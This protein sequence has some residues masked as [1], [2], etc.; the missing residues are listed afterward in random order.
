MTTLVHRILWRAGAGLSL[1]AA[2]PAMASPIVDSFIVK[3]SKGQIAYRKDVTAAEEDP[4]VIFFIDAPGLANI[5]QLNNATTLLDASGD[6]ADI[7][8][9]ALAGSQIDFFLA[10]SSGTQGHPTPFGGSGSISLPKGNGGVFDATM[11]LDDGLQQQG[12]TASYVTAV[13]AV[14]DPGMAAPL[15]GTAMMGLAWLRRKQ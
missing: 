4:T 1:A 6:A 7:F 9:V 14:P 13:D 3:D 5:N 8:G 11:Y 15:L 10:F 12:W 2:L